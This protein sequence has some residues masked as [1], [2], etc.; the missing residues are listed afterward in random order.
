MV[1]GELRNRSL[2]STMWPASRVLTPLS[3]ALGP[4]YPVSQGL[5]TSFTISA[6][7]GCRKQHPTTQA[8]AHM[9]ML[10]HSK[11]KPYS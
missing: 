11:R 7:G 6:P 8:Y 2:D 3:S 5:G 10:I 9:L 1:Q 4:P